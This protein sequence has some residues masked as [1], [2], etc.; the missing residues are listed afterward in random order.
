[1][2][3][4]RR[5]RKYKLSNPSIDSAIGFNNTE[6]V[7]K[8]RSKSNPKRHTYIIARNEDGTEHQ[9]TS[10]VTWD[11]QPILRLDVSGKPMVVIKEFEATTYDEARAIYE[12][13]FS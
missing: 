5:S 12:Q 6:C 1:M 3:F 13:I 7:G 10:K 11:N 9:L 8:Q 2:N 4:Q